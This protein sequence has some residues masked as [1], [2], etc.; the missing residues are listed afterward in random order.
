[1]KQVVTCWFEAVAGVGEVVRSGLVRWDGWRL[2]GR[3]QTPLLSRISM[4][5]PSKTRWY[6][7]GLQFTKEEVRLQW[8]LASEISL[9]FYGTHS[10]SEAVLPEGLTGT[11]A[12]AM[13]CGTASRF[14]V[15]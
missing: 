1:V 13:W 3:V 14:P 2:S 5:V 4:L 9:V 11:P 12:A 10:N 6:E 7:C 15:A 8:F